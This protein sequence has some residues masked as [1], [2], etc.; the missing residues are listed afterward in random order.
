VSKIVW[1]E[2]DRRTRL[3][4]VKGEPTQV[5]TTRYDLD[6][7]LDDAAK[8]FGE[9]LDRIGPW[10][11]DGGRDPEDEDCG[12]NSKVTCKVQRQLIPEAS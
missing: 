6:K 12:N 7:A 9:P 1:A 4:L 2:V 8:Y 5:Q 3:G 11:T 10:L